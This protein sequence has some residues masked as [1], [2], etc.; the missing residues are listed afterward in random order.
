[1]LELDPYALLQLREDGPVNIFMLDL[2][3][4]AAAQAHCDKHVVKMILETAQLLSSAWHALDNA[5]YRP[6]AEDPADDQLTP[7][8]QRIVK[9]AETAA[10]APLKRERV[11]PGESPG[12]CWELH[13]Q[14]IYNKTHENHPSAVWA[15]ELGGNY[16]WLW[17]LGAAL[18]AEYTHRYGKRHATESVLWTLEAVPP[19]L[20]ASTD[21]WTECPP[22]MPDECKVV[23]DGF[24]DTVLSY[25]TYYMQ[26]KQ[27]LLH[28]TKRPP[29]SWAEA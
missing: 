23:V 27:Q 21:S 29:P 14:R 1:M 16:L 4:R 2:D 13:G 5:M 20:L 12:S 28:W 19:S 3:P 8:L 7:W 22:T 24:Y 10:A 25:R 6:L 18:C 11:L 15:R 9:P 26:R 17:R